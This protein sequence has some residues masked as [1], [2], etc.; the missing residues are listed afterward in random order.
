MP[1]RKTLLMFSQK[2]QFR[3]G[4]LLWTTRIIAVLGCLYSGLISSPYCCVFKEHFTFVSKAL[5]YFLQT[6][7]CFFKPFL[8]L[9]FVEKPAVWLGSH[10]VFGILLAILQISVGFFWRANLRA[11]TLLVYFHSQYQNLLKE[12]GRQNGVGS[13]DCVDACINENIHTH[14]CILANNS[15]NS[16]QSFRLNGSRVL[17][18]CCEWKG[19]QFRKQGPT[20]FNIIVRGFILILRNSR[21]N[22]LGDCFREGGYDKKIS[23]MVALL[24]LLKINNND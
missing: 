11:E 8:P 23:V 6:E 3:M 21:D 13:G 1:N 4:I 14:L 10:P 20:H 7:K 19:S 15:I 9:D 24:L 5:K 16:S 2:R 12:L 17:A 22:Y 18:S